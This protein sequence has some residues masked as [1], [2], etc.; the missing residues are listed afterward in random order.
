MAMAGAISTLFG[1]MAGFPLF[2]RGRQLNYRFLCPN[3]LS[4]GGFDFACGKCWTQ[5][6]DYDA[7]NK[8]QTCAYCQ[9]SLLSAQGYNVRAYCKQ[10]KS[11]C[12]SAPYHQRQ[13]RTLATLRPSDFASLYLAISGHEY[14]PQG[15]K[16]YVY[17]DSERLSYVLNLSDFNDEAHSLPPAHA[18][19]EVQSIWL[20]ASAS[21]PKELAL[22][23]GESADLYIA[24]ARLTEERRRTTIVCVN[25]AEA[26]PVVKRVLGTRFGKVRYRVTASDFLFDKPKIKALAVGVIG[27]NSTVPALI[28][29]LRD[30][31]FNERLRA[32]M[33]LRRIND[34]SALPMLREALKDKYAYVRGNVAEALGNIGDNLA[35]PGLRETLKDNVGYVRSAAVA[36]LVKIGDNSAV[37]ELRAADRKYHEEYDCAFCE[38][39]RRLEAQ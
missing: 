18:L 37:P 8:T 7:A 16:G 34:K 9:R 38:A 17:D 20:D 15:G 6:P 5:I 13:V 30:R 4:F 12:D 25:Q 28:S 29:A 2:K 11:N 39:I 32:A 31:N 33:S 35:A 24:R 22:E 14:Q 27:H 1:K 3:C 26:D 10:C 36:A 21:S 19:W 23:L